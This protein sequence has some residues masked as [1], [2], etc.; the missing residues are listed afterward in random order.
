MSN[1]IDPETINYHD[2]RYQCSKYGPDYF[3]GLLII[4]NI[5]DE[6]H[7]PEK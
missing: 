7:F 5:N 4:K 2:L 6:P 3:F 1:V